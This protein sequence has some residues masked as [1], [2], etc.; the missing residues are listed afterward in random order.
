[1]SWSVSWSAKL[2]DA[3]SHSAT[4]GASSFAAGAQMETNGSAQRRRSKFHEDVAAREQAA[5]PLARV[6]EAVGRREHVRTAVR[7]IVFY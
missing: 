7:K 5:C 2:G 6:W 3:P 1:M 4:S